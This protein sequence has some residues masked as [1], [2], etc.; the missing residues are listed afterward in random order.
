MNHS[1]V[2]KYGISTS[3]SSTQLHIL[4]HAGIFDAPQVARRKFLA[5]VVVTCPSK[6]YTEISP[7]CQAS[8]YNYIL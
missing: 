6:A 4:T 7:E 3:L 5:A 8:E 1:L 2:I